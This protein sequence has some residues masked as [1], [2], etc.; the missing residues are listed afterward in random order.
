M[1]TAPLDGLIE[2]VNRPARRVFSLEKRHH[3][4]DHQATYEDWSEISGSDADHREPWSPTQALGRLGIEVVEFKGKRLTQGNAQ[5]RRVSVRPGSIDPFQTLLHEV[6]HVELGHTKIRKEDT[7]EAFEEV[8]AETVAFCV[9][10]L[11]GAITTHSV[12]R[13]RRYVARYRKQLGRD[14]TAQEVDALTDV[15]WRIYYAG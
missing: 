3:V 15:T 11:L 13:H 14:L 8:T 10:A 4:W 7:N 9:S 5:G 2:R 6:A 12:H 1:E